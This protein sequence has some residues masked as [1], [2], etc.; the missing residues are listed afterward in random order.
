MKYHKIR[1]RA[2]FRERPHLLLFNAGER[3][4]EF[5]L[6][7]PRYGAQW[8]KVLDTAVPVISAQDLTIAKPGDPVTVSGRSLQVLRR[9]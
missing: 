4:L 6:P 9:D 2:E 5:T 3:D 1:G 8:S 7:P